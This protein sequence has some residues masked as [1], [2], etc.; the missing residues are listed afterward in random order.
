[1]TAHRSTESAH[2]ESPRLTPAELGARLAATWPPLTD[3]QIEAAARILA[4]V[5]QERAA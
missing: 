5:V 1:M 2:V 4:T 3:E